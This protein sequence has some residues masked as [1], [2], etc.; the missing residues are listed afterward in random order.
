MKPFFRKVLSLQLLTTGKCFPRNFWFKAATNISI[1]RWIYF[2]KYKKHKKHSTKLVY[3]TNF[4]IKDC[5][6]FTLMLT[7]FTCLR[8]I[9][10]I[11]K[12]LWNHSIMQ[13]FVYEIFFSNFHCIYKWRRSQVFYRIAVLERFLKVPLRLSLPVTRCTGHNTDLPSNS[14]ISKRGRVNIAFTRTSFK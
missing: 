5:F 14:N 13:Q 10:S 12:Y 2:W 1:C 6:C 8:F 4:V 11:L 9:L 3:L 7:T